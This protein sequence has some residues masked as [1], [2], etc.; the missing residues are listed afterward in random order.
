MA[1]PKENKCLLIWLS[2]VCLS[3]VFRIVE[4][5]K[6]TEYD[7]G[8]IKPSAFGIAIALFIVFLITVVFATSFVSAFA[9]EAKRRQVC[10]L[11]ISL[12]SLALGVATAI[13]CVA[14]NYSGVPGFL[15]ILCICFGVLSALFFI[16]FALR[17][18][19]YFWFSPLLSAIP[20]IFFIVKSAVIFIKCSYHALIGDTVF[21]VGAYC[22]SMLVF[23]EIA[24]SANKSG[25]KNSIKRFSAFS[26][27]ASIFLF[28]A[29]IPKILISVFYPSAL[30]TG[31]GDSMFLL[32]LGAF[33]SSLLFTRVGFANEAR[34]RN[35]FYY[36]GKH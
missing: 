8:F 2:A 33:I 16:A 31:V 24:R 5:L 11:M 36:A 25:G 7:T 27:S 12:F 18:F 21:D 22:L 19:I 30:H 32:F 13:S 15:R 9:A 6:L 23:L 1:F 4:M 10:S 26:A 28:C 14:D 17:P 35:G 3:V 34:L 29:S 20:L